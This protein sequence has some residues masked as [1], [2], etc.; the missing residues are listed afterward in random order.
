MMKS[1]FSMLMATNTPPTQHF[2][3]I[4][5]LRGLTA[6]V[7][8]F[9]HFSDFF[10]PKTNWLHLAFGQGYLGVEAFF[11]ISGMV[12]PLSFAQ[13]NYDIS[14]LKTVVLKRIIRIEPAYWASILLMIFIDVFGSLY[15]HR[16]LPSFT[17]SDFFLHVFHANAVFNQPWLRGIYWTL[18][19]DW[20]F[21][22]VLCLA[23]PLFNRPEWWARYPLY[24]VFLV[25][26]WS[27]PYAWLPYHIV[28]FGA[29]VALFHFYRGYAHR[30]ELAVILSALLFAHFKA[31]GY[32]HCLA[33]ALSVGIILFVK[34]VGSMGKALGKISYSYYLTHVFSGWTLL[35]S[36]ATFTRDPTILTFAVFA[37]VG[38][39][40]PFA[41]WFYNW[42]EAPTMA[43]AKKVS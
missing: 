7:V 20:Q 3:S 23:F 15:E 42:V 31:F 19:I 40:I 8:A 41:Q 29:G 18:A 13:K 30:W 25:A 28:P 5:L 16:P 37:A 4:D 11:V 26:H 43:W 32:E 10:L 6:I 24:A 17:V 36:L 22:I 34:E 35:N 27:A 14:Q 33:T 21:Y 12:I 2:E 39:S 38:I 9:Y 1:K